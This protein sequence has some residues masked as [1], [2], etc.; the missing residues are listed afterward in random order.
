MI[1]QT[2]YKRIGK[3]GIVPF[4]VKKDITLEILTSDPSK[5]GVKK[6]FLSGGKF[7]GELVEARIQR[8]S[9]KGNWIRFGQ[10]KGF[11]VI[12]EDKKGCWIVPIDNTTPVKEQKMDEVITDSEQN[13]NDNLKSLQSIEPEKKI[14]GFTYKQIAIVAVLVLIARKL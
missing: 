4:S 14:F 13:T 3:N 9:D 6:T 8:K 10:G 7:Q 12:D 11:M 1:T 5:E 2:Q